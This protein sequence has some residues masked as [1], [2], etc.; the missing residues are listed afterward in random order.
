MGKGLKLFS[1]LR[2]LLFII[3][4]FVG[5]NVLRAATPGTTP[6]PLPTNYP[7]PVVIKSLKSNSM[8]LTASLQSA[9][10]AQPMDMGTPVAC[11]TITV[12]GL[13]NCPD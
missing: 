6:T 10:T 2:I 12:D 4:S 9:S 8:A 5:V 7:T 11:S 3:L 1:T 13:L